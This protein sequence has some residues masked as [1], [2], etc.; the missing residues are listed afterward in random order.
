MGEDCLSHSGDKVIPS[1]VDASSEA[2]HPLE[3]GDRPF[4]SGTESLGMSEQRV[5]FR[6]D[7]FGRASPLLRDG[8]DR[9]LLPEPCQSLGAV[10]VALVRSELVGVGT[11]E[12]L[13]ALQ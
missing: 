7:L 13:M 2:E 5:V 12:A 9:D 8:D 6:F 4:D 11:E 10:I 1:F 3:K